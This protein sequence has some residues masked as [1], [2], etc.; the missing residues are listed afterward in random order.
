MSARLELDLGNTRGKWRL[1]KGESVVQRGHFERGDFD[2]LDQLRRSE[3]VEAIW[4]ASVAGPVLEQELLA[5]LTHR[6]A[7]E[8]WLPR[9]PAACGRLRNSYNDPQ[10]MGVDRWLAMLAAF[11][12]HPEGVC[13]VDAGSALTIDLVSGEG[14]HLGGYIIPGAGLMEAALLRG[15]DRVRFAEE[16]GYHLLPGRSTAEA[17]KH[18]IALAQVGAV[19]TALAQAP[20]ELP[21][22][23]SGGGGAILQ[24]LLGRGGVW[25]EDLVFEGLARMAMQ[26]P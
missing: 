9:T 1:L 3:E 16:V 21:L 18:G 24:T 2:S 10:R 8:P 11:E 15:T 23:F 26:T 13:V 25:V 19:T 14:E 4:I 22:V 12:R 17:V 7:V 20:T 6:W 5:A